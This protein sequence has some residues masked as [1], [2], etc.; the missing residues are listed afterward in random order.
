MSQKEGMRSIVQ[1]GSYVQSTWTLATPNSRANAFRFQTSSCEI[2]RVSPLYG[3]LDEK[4]PL[5]DSP[6]SGYV[7]A[8]CSG[9]CKLRQLF[10]GCLSNCIFTPFK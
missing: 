1:C 4:R 9:N 5:P 6:D 3:F 10:Y 8:T 7:L 2:G